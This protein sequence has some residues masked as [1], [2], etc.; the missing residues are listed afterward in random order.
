MEQPLSTWGCRLSLKL[1][2]IFFKKNWS[3]L[4]GVRGNREHVLLTIE[5]LNRRNMSITENEMRL[6]WI[7]VGVGR[8]Q[9]QD[10][11]YK[12]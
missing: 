3:G 6:V 10:K 1:R 2:E 9:R 11:N 7:W 5:W 12:L 4:R 8:F